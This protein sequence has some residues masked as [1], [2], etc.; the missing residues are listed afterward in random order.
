MCLCVCVCQLVPPSENVASST[1]PDTLQRRLPDEPD[2]RMGDR[3]LPYPKRNWIPH[4]HKWPPLCTNHLINKLQAR[5][6]F[7]VNSNSNSPYKC[8]HNLFDAKRFRYK[9]AI[10]ISICVHVHTRIHAHPHTRAHAHRYISVSL[11]GKERCPCPDIV[12]S[13]LFWIGYFNSTLNPLIYAYFNR[14]FREAF[15][16]T[17]Q[18]VF[19]T[20]WRSEGYAMEAMDVRRSSLRFESRA[21]SV[22]SEN[23]LKAEPH[24]H[25]HHHHHAGRNCDQTV[26]CL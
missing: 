22:Y 25:H 17:L 14:D 20:W 11:C 19:C 3:S 23:Y 4:T 13:I 12:V 5:D 7:P 21:K 18:C 16:S 2:I 10:N 26:D 8:P 24:H 1:N 6:V 9:H 15:R